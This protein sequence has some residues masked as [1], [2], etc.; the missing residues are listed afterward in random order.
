MSNAPSDLSCKELVELVTGYLEGTLAPGVRA[1]FESH[2]SSCPGSRTY[3]KQMRLT[4][5][6]LGN[7]REDFV[8]AEEKARL[9]QHFRDYLEDS[10]WSCYR[11]S[12]TGR[13]LELPQH[14]A[15]NKALPPTSLSRETGNSW[16][17][18]PPHWGL[19]GNKRTGGGSQD[20][21]GGGTRTHDLG[22]M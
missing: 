9:V 14:D 22:I 18:G 8:P 10:K 13:G 15:F 2:L 1:R 3:L 20:C 21:A 12:G 16:A 11:F 6:R 7:L 17:Q 5:G 4:I 19:G